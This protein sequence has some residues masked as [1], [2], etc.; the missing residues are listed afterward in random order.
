MSEL[1][2]ILKQ[3]Y[4]Y[5]KPV[6]V[7][8]LTGILMSSA[9]TANLKFLKDLVNQMTSFSKDKP[10]GMSENGADWSIMEPVYYLMALIILLALIAAICRYLHFY[11]MDVVSEK[12]SINLRRQLQK[13]FLTLNLTFHNSYTTGSGGLLSRVTNDVVVIHHGLRL[14]AD[15]FREPVLLL[16]M[17]G[18]LFYINWK[19]TLCILVLLPLISLFLKQLARSL[20]KYG[21]KSQE[22]LEKITNTLKESLEGIRVIQSFNLEKELENR[23]ERETHE[24]LKARK[25]VHSRIEA[26][27]PVTEFI[28]TTLFVG[29]TVYVGFEIISGETSLGDFIWYTGALLSLQ[30][31]VKKLQESF[32]RV[33]ETLVSIKRVFH[34]IEDT[35]MVS[36]T[37]TPRPFPSSWQL[38]EF[39]NVTFKFKD[40]TVL[41]NFNLKIR[42]GDILALVGSSGS[43][44][45][46]AANLLQRFYDP[47]QGDI[48]ID[49][50]SI[51]E[52]SLKE[53]RQ[54]IALVSQD[55]FLFNESINYN[56]LSGN[57]QK[58]HEDVFSAAR[59]ANAS[60]F[61][62]QKPRQYET[63]VG[64]QGRLLSGGEKQRVSIARAILKNAPLLILDEATSA[65][66]SSSEVEVQKGL[67][68]LMVNKTALIIAHRL[69][70]ISSVHRIIVLD[71]G[72]VVEQGDHE[73]LINKKGFYYQFYQHQQHDRPH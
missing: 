17:L 21:H 53:L 25:K 2:K 55:V 33:Q 36:E 14:V 46:T 59:L 56:I 60:H 47:H 16:C 27:G 62:E 11:I 65:L 22:I 28:V 37:P 50:M 30:K 42:R 73:T 58:T 64:E 34:I 10:L 8:A 72:R 71:K 43:G 38:I 26:S 51:K 24:Y 32:V 41:E 1:K 3:I 45:S 20:R 52:F 40:R 5:K 12:I 61:I 57:F 4:P 35:S 48:L 18:T 70:T 13:K 23:F 15:F 49:G 31:P 9:Q 67:D 7:V 54:N 66:D 19:L 6:F 29:L 39:K 44:K 63:I 68:Q 69:S